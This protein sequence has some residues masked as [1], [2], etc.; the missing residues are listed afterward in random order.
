MVLTCKILGVNPESYLMW[1][2]P[3]LAAASNRSAD[4]LLPHDYARLHL[5][6]VAP[7][8]VVPVHALRTVTFVFIE[9]AM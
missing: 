2:L 8:G 6:A 4:G 9:R 1:V 5:G 3:K 7:G